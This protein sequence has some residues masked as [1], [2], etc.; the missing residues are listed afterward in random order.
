MPFRP[1]MTSKL[2]LAC[3][4]DS[5][6]GG[7]VAT[8]GAGSVAANALAPPLKK[9]A[10]MLVWGDKRPRSSSEQSDAT[11]AAGNTRRSRGPKRSRIT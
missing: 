7:S 5:T 8:Y 2:A 6:V 11:R 9:E 3:M 1:D 10:E 4:Q